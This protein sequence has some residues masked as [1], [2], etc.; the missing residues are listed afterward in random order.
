MVAHFSRETHAIANGLWPLAGVDEVGRGPLAG[1]VVAAA[2]ILDPDAIPDGLDDSKNLT[3][4]RREELFAL[5]TESA[6]AI[7][8][9]SATAVEIDTINIRQATLLAMRRAVSALPVAP[10]S[11]LVDGNDPPV[12]ACRC[13]SIIGGDAL[14]ASIAAASI[15]AKVARDAMMAR[16]CQRYPA[17]GFSAHAGY[18]TARHRSALTTHGPCPEHRYSFA[19]VKGVWFRAAPAPLLAGL[20]TG[21][22]APD[23]A[24]AC[25]ARP[26]PHPE[27]ES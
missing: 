22:L 23:L 12:L 14:I 8:V 9:A 21:L 10:A 5:I 1:P 2:V 3:A 16:L 20:E 18:A 27:S 26:S 17:Y 6:L 11:V 13:E 15:V 24:L 4:A 25:A 7:G 19:P